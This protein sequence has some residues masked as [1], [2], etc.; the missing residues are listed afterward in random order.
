MDVFLSAQHTFRMSESVLQRRVLARMNALGLKAAP[1]AKKANLGDSFVRDIL[2]GKTTTPKADNLA[3]LAEA[4]ET[5]PE[6][7]LGGERNQQGASSGVVG[8]PDLAIFAGMGGG[9]MLE[10]YVDGDGAP[11]DPDQVRGYWG[12]PDYVIRRLGD[13]RNVYAWEARGDSM[14]PTI[15]SGSV[16]FVDTKQTMLPPDDIYALNYGDGLVVKRLK[17][18]PRTDRVSVISDNERYPPDELLRD[19]VRIWGRVIGSFQWRD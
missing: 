5:T 10:V 11:S 13:I 17:L 16:V 3:A 18:I 4:L 14:E 7:L 9:G 8:I 12:F 6:Y 15:M 19:E 1:L 2:R